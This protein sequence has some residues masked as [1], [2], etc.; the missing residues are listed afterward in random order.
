MRK[1]SLRWNLVSNEAQTLERYCHNCGKKVIFTDSKLKRHNANGKNIYQY[2]IFKC[3]KGHTWNKSIYIYKAVELGEDFDYRDGLNEASVD[4]SG[5]TGEL[6]LKISI[7]S[8][9]ALGFEAVEIFI[10]VANKKWRLDKLLGNYVEDLSRTQ[11]KK[12]IEDGRFTVDG[13]KVKADTAVRPNQTIVLSI[14]G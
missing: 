9:Q 11:I 6:P 12:Y 10:A 4:S 5:I 7:N 3:E 1:L 14:T 13:K 2:A 8:Y